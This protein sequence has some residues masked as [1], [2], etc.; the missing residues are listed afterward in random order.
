[1]GRGHARGRVIPQGGQGWVPPTRVSPRP[2]VTGGL[3]LMS[4]A[5]PPGLASTR[6]R[7]HPWSL[8]TV[9]YLMLL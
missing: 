4:C 7:G 5:V 3:G 6:G 9:V 1:M 8:F 2:S